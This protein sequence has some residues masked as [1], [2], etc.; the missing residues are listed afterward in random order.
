MSNIIRIDLM[1]HKHIHECQ[2]CSS[3]SLVSVMF[4]GYV[5]PVNAMQDI[6]KGGGVEE[7]YPLEFTRCTECHLVQLN[8]EVDQQ[9]VFPFSYPY[10][11]G[12]TRI[13]R[14][15]FQNLAETC[16]MHNYIEEGQLVIDIGSNDGS[17]LSPFKNKGATVLGIEPTQAG[18]VAKKNGIETLIAYFNEE[19]AQ[20]VLNSTGTAKIITAANVFAHMP[21]PGK[22]VQSITNL[23]DKN[24]IFI[25]ENHYLP[26]ITKGLQYD[27]IYHEHL[28][29]YHLGSLSALLQ[30]H[31]L[32]IF[33]AELIPTHGGSIRVYSAVTGSRKKTERL[34]ELMRSEDELRLNSNDWCDDFKRNV[35]QSKFDL[36]NML[37]GIRQKGQQI[38]G[39]GAPSRA[40]TLLTYCGIDESLVACVMELPTSAKINKYMPGTRIPVLDE[41]KLYED[42]PEY[43]LLL[44]WHIA[45]ELIPI[46][47]RKGFRGK[48]I[49][50]LPEVRIEE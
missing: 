35:E 13:L 22:I 15:N 8:Y 14:D 46:L 4:L 23:M 17:L 7:T 39:I 28:R 6:G 26:S 37:S 36:I 18:E 43:A 38:Y 16:F 24:S 49:I 41:K 42:Q 50:P 47:K 25:S 44:S 1:A 34:K 45:D 30:P 9:T 19:T 33:D 3:P 29:Y 2:I 48:F 10:L 20:E 5:P 32:E 27:T 21:Q 11:S 31:N 12:S 40:S